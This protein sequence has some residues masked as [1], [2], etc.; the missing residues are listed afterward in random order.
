M[1]HLKDCGPINRYM[2]MN[3]LKFLVLLSMLLLAVNFAEAKGIP[4]C[5]KKITRGC[6][7]H[8][9]GQTA[10]YYSTP[11]YNA[12]HFLAKVAKVKPKKL[13]KNSNHKKLGKAKR[14]TAS[15]L[16]L[17]LKKKKKK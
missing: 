8:K 6:V 13:A 17:K 5:T 1:K 16:E 3:T 12:H 9:R 10:K 14:S 7:K 11:K 4:Y 15:V 2:I